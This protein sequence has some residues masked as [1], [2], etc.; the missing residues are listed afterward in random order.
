MDLEA[1]RY[2]MVQ[3]QVQP[4]HVLNKRVLQAMCKM[5]REQFVPANYQKLAFA[6]TNIPLNHNQFMHSP[7]FI[8][9]I[10]QS[11]DVTKKHENILEIGTGSGYLTALLAKFAKNVTSIEIF[12]QLSELAATQLQKLAI[13]NVQF[14]VGNGLQGC[15]EPLLF[16]AIILTGS[17]PYLPKILQQQVKVGGRLF[18][19]LGQSPNMRAMLLKRIS[20]D[21]W[22]ETVLFDTDI[23]SLFHV[24]DVN[25]FQF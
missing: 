22:D 18:A 13:N 2:N 24:P 11:L 15:R 12:S 10:L 3:N 5:P 19:I 25:R 9:R 1:A 4:W 8:G 21:K 7:K 17:V 6:D 14:I 16:D 23:Q 20:E